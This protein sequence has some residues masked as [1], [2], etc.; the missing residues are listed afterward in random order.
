V[1]GRNTRRLLGRA[2]DYT[3][4]GQ[5]RLAGF[6]TPVQVWQVLGTRALGSRFEAHS[7]SLTLLAGRQAELQLLQERWAQAAGGEGQVV[8]LSGE[9]GIGKSRIVHELPVLLMLHH[10]RIRRYQC[11]PFHCNTAL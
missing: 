5:H 2:F 9:A 11:S 3:N 1:I 8:L 7:V 10:D 6:S 4:L